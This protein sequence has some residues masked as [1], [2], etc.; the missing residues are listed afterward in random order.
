MRSISASDAN[1]LAETYAL[2]FPKAWSSNQFSELLDSGAQGWLIA[3]KAFIIIRTAAD[4]A[5]IITIATAP[6]YRQKGYASNL[7]GKAVEELKVQ[8]VATMF[9][10]V[11]ADNKS[12]FKLYTKHKF[13]QTSIRKDYYKLPDNT[14]KD[15]LIMRLELDK[16]I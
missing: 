8:S 9:L 7:L 16:A 3:N 13:T 15:A 6:E 4:E 10:E 12:A 1:W 11:S 5:E 14:R 2:S